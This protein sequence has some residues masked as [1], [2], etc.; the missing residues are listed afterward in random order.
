MLLFRFIVFGLLGLSALSFAFYIG[1]G[2]ARYRT[3]GLR[4]LRW[5]LVAG[6]AF[7]AVLVLERIA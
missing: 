7:F 5:V 6:L 3:W 1:T 2:E 4:L